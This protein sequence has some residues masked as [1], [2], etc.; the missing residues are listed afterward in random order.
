VLLALPGRCGL[1][2]AG[3]WLSGVGLT[4]LLAYSLVSPPV[5]TIYEQYRELEAEG[6]IERV[7]RAPIPYSAKDYLRDYGD[8]GIEAPLAADESPPLA[9]HRGERR[10]RR[11]AHDPRRRASRWA[12]ASSPPASR[13]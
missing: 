5:L 11:R 6:R 4:A 13:W 8:T 1:R 3:G 7:V 9:G 12:S 10:G 2:Q